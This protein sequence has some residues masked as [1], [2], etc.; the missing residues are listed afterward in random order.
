MLS[1]GLL[2]SMSQISAMDLDKND[3][4]FVTNFLIMAFDFGTSQRIAY[5]PNIQHQFPLFFLDDLVSPILS[6]TMIGLYASNHKDL[7]CG[8]SG[9]HTVYAISRRMALNDA[10]R[11][12]EEQ[13]RKRFE[14]NAEAIKKRLRANAPKVD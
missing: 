8:L 10:I 5:N 7:L 13:A 2:F 4:V 1:L 11:K 6:I 14:A 9:F 12:D 3:A